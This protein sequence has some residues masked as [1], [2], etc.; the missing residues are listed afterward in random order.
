MIL[1]KTQFEGK[2]ERMASPMDSI[3]RKTTISVVMPQ[4]GYFETL[5]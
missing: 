3:A 2:E 5:L 4:L 1:E